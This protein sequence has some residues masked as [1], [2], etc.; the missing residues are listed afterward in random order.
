M[1][2][3]STQTTFPWRQDSLPGR[4]SVL[5]KCAL[6]LGLS[7]G[8]I[9]AAQERVVIAPAGEA[10]TAE[11]V[12]AEELATHLRALY[13]S[14]KFETGAPAAG[15]PVIYLGTA[16]DLPSRFT[17]QISAKLVNPESFVI[18]ANDNQGIR[19]AV[20][21]GAS[22]RAT[23]FAVYA[24]LEK[25][26]FGFY[27][28]YNTTPAPSLSP[29]SFAGWEMSDTPVV[30]ERVIFDWHNFLSGCSTWNLQDWQ[31]WVTQASRMRFN[32]VMVHAYGNNPMF[33][34]SMN[35]ETKPA[36]YLPNTRVG[37][38]WGTQ[39]VLD[40][41]KIVGAEGLFSGP[42]FGADASMVSDND[43]VAAATSLMQDVFRFA[44]NRAVG[45][46]FALDVDTESAN[47]QNVIKT[48]PASARFEH[49]GMQLVNPDTAEGYA[50]YRAEIEQLMKL[51]P[52][53]T[54]LAVWF[55]GGL[56]S[57]WRE[58]QPD[59]FPA[60]WRE[61][62]RAAL[63]SNPRLKSDPEAPSMFAIGKIAKAFRKAL[64][65]TGHV[66]VTMSAGS[67]RFTYLP[68]ADVFMPASVAL[69]PLD[70][71]YGFL[72]DPVQ[73]S[74]RAIGRHRPTVPIVWAQHDDREYAGRSY[75]PFAGFGSLLRWSNSAGYGVIHWTTRPL[76]LFFKSVADQV[77]NATE[78]E[79]LDVTTA[80]MAKRTFGPRA[81]ELGKRYLYS[82]I[83]DAPAFGMET[84]DTFINQAID[85]D[86]EAH[87]AKARLALLA[88]MRP[89]AQDE[90]ARD[91]IGYF[92]D[93]ERYAQGFYQSQT[94]MQ[95]SQAALKAGDLDLARRE[96]AAAKSESVI[97]QYSKTIRHGQIS[98]GEKGILITLNLRWLPHIEAQ[99]QALGLEPIQVEFAPT[100]HE[101][102]AQGAG[103]YSFDFDGS[104]KV[105]EV[106]GPSELD[107]DVQQFEAGAR[108]PSGIEIHSPVTLAIGGLAGSRLLPGTYRMKLD[109]PD[110]VQVEVES[111]GSRR[112]VTSASEIEMRA[113][114]GKIRFTLSPKSGSIRVCGLT[115][116]WQ[117]S[118]P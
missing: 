41:R 20:I 94:A 92:E 60:A 79:S 38:D 76:D 58:L 24:L 113:S 16:Q 88:Q 18:T 15:S 83:Y 48:L 69:M 89:L 10:G 66:S 108:C 7:M 118:V 21:A 11:K 84:S 104:K 12:A 39:H 9:A 106:L 98:P 56:N 46:T 33:S 78:N 53:I 70:Y 103:H 67:W 35:G 65:E 71:D 61:E 107:V 114:D 99:R 82:W 40:V 13:P 85:L 68:S 37:R 31:H 62:Y 47:P 87:G 25:L 63:E 36:G 77:W 51:Y 32:T 43:R 75:T 96:I 86:V 105:I 23:L 102:L 52:Q 55:R 27:L 64:D 5:I 1:I 14:T 100:N 59:E 3:R 73:E 116:S 115:L 30:G 26:G 6:M 97:E 110:G 4:K 45:V 34:F 17:T 8:T 111:E 57:P 50:Y 109:M 22:P 2:R 90:T 95:K 19:E 80:E 117:P 72:S 29:F 81:Q 54:Q 74:L 101:P 49:R 42:V 91:W 44:A 93:W 28:S 112:A